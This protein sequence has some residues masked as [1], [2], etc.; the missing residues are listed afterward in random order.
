[1]KLFLS[2]LALVLVTITAASSNA[3]TRNQTPDYTQ[4]ECLAKNIYFESK[5]DNI[6]GQAA[7]A[8]V[9][10]NRVN[11]TQYPNTVCEVIY[12]GPHYESWKTR[13]TPDPN[14]AVFYPV[15]HRC[16]FSWYCDGKADDPV[17]PDAYQK[18]YL[19][20]F[21]MI[22]NDRY[23]GISDGA[24]HYHATYV[25]PHWAPN[26]QLIGRIGLHIFYKSK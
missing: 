17:E 9:V 12:Q 10:L 4:I 11:S 16:Q 24:T 25:K 2:V 21:Q 7:V 8:D 5:S 3:Y 26:L 20:A 13:Q 6:A 22:T 15:K 1:M 19:I 23:R 14:D 18:A